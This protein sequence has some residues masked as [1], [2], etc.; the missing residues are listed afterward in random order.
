MRLNT[1]ACEVERLE[2][3]QNPSSVGLILRQKAKK[4]QQRA[5][6]NCFVRDFRSSHDAEAAA[7]CR[8]IGTKRINSNSKV[9]IQTIVGL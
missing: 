6:R 9:A 4:A 2:Y 8:M 1:M 7:V 3:G 5:S